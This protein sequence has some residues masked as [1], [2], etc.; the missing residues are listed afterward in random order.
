MLRQ[1]SLE[2]PVMI[3]HVSGHVACAQQ[4]SL[5]NG[6]DYQGFAGSGRRGHWKRIWFKESNGYLEE[7][8]M[9]LI[10]QLIQAKLE[11]DYN[12]MVEQMQ[13]IYIQHGV[14][15]VQEGAATKEGVQMLKKIADNGQLKIDVVAYPMLNDDGKA[16]MDQEK[17]LA[18]RY[19]NRL[20][21]GGFK[22]VLD[23]SPPGALCLAVQALS[24][25]RRRILRLSMDVR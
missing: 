25:R 6:R 24:D 1:V 7:A 16:V 5:G 22:L 8:G 20:K 9:V 4:Q 19:E 14:T 18:G 21:I 3:M 13:E 10:Q 12:A 15:T 17:E 2:I 11:F 23:G